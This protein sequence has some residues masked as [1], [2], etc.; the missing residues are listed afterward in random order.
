MSPTGGH[1]LVC[2]I[3]VIGLMISTYVSDVAPAIQITVAMIY[4]FLLIGGNCFIC[5]MEGLMSY[6]MCCS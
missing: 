6:F 5:D 1:L 4:P 2:H 3:T